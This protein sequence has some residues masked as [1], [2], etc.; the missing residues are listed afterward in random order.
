MDNFISVSPGVYVEAAQLFIH[1]LCKV[2]HSARD[3][4]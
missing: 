2:M 1:W 3:G 4:E